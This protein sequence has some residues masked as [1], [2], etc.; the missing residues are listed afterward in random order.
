MV[1]NARLV[2]Y[3][4]LRQNAVV[5]KEQLPKGCLF[6]AVVKA[7]AYGHGLIP[8]VRTLRET[9]DWFAVATVDEALACRTVT[10]KPVLLLSPPAKGGEELA[11]GDIRC[12]VSG[13]ED[14]L[15]LSAAAERA[16]KALKVHLAIDCGMHRLGL[17][18]RADWKRAAD[19]LSAS[20]RLCVEGLMTHFCDEDPCFT[21][22]NLKIFEKARRFFL[23]RF[24]GLLCHAAATSFVGDAQ[25]GFGMVR[26][27]LALYG[28][29]TALPVHPCLRFEAGVVCV[30]TVPEGET[31]GYGRTFRTRRKTRLCVISAGYADGYPRILSNRGQV[32]IHG[33]LCPVVGRVCMDLLMV[34]ATKVKVR[35][36]DR[37]VLFSPDRPELS[38]ER[39]AVLADTI[40]Y[41]L[42]TN[43]NNR[44]G[45][46]PDPGSR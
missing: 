13:P 11:Q 39:N 26:C 17:W 33:K 28:Y 32:E 45:L 27:G 15:R 38:L 25:K 46:M 41:E 9:A 2:D 7:N 24:P 19:L 8:S 18:S 44:S 37:A 6:C 10:E 42:L 35:P 29:G 1:R 3:K 4:R 40:V 21:E 5:L 34:D 43:L 23:P 16:G 30:R 31:V 22:Q 12:V 20:P 36:G 14:I